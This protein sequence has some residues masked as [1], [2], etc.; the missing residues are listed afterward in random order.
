[1]AD[2]NSDANLIPPDL[3][4]EGLKHQPDIKIDEGSPSHKLKGVNGD[5]CAPCKKK[6]YLN[7][8]LKIS[9]GQN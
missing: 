8:S 5:V 7:V 6:E 1:M 2:H 4:Q 3:M 9:Q